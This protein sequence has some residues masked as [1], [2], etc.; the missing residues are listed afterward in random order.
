MR[1]SKEAEKQ[2]EEKADKSRKKDAKG[3]DKGRDTAK[4]RDPAPQ[5]PK[6]PAPPQKKGGKPEKAKPV[7]LTADMLKMGAASYARTDDKRKGGKSS[8]APP[9]FG[10]D[11]FPAFPALSKSPAAFP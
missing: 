6:D 4:D 5:V 9:S 7:P 2:K 1:I 10:S 3:A 11:A 8:Q